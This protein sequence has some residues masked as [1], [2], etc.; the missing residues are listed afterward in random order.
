MH[1]QAAKLR[2]AVGG[3][4]GSSPAFHH[5]TALGGLHGR[6]DWGRAR[7]WNSLKYV[8]EDDPDDGL[9]TPDIS[10]P[11]AVPGAH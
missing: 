3:G 11:L 8:P 9:S 7:V 2:M 5:Q 1:D 4:P 10:H 6:F